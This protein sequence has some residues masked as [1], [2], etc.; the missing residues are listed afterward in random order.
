MMSL[1]IHHIFPE[2]WCKKRGLKPAVSNTIVNKTPISYKANR[3]I[4]GHAP[5][6][7]LPKL[8]GEKLVGL[9]DATMD[10]LLHTHQIPA[11]CLR[12][13]DFDGFYQARK[14][15]LL[16][17]VEQAMGKTPLANVDASN[18]SNGGEDELEPQ[19]MGEIA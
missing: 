4:G 13:D 16:Q 8:Q 10:A 18:D 5:S 17:L 3:K 6:V 12:A 15:R 14:A 11:K 19:A 1:D 7:Y 2:D 9:D